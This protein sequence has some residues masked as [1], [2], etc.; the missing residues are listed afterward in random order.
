M[1]TS[2]YEL[3]AVRF[4]RDTTGFSRELRK[5]IDAYFKE[6]GG[7]HTANPFMVFKTIFYFTLLFLPWSLMAFGY[8]G[9]G[10]MFWAAYFLM[11][12]GLAG[13][14]MNVMHDANHK[15]Y[16]KKKWTNTVISRSIEFIGGNAEMWRIQHNVLHHSFTN[17]DGLDEDIDP[18]GILRFSPLK[19]LYKIHRFQYI[20][21]WFFY[22]LMTLVW[23]L[24]KD[25]V[26]LFDY[27]K[28]GLLKR[29]GGKFTPLLILMIL[30]KA[31]FYGYTM[32]LPI[33]YSGAGVGQV[34][35]G[36]LLMHFVAGFLLGII[37]QC[38]HVMEDH[39]YFPAEKGAIID[40]DVLTHAVNT[41]S[42]F[43]MKSK[44]L[45]FI[46]GGLNF[47][48]E[49]HLFPHICHV[50]YPKIAPIVKKTAEEF[51]V[52]YGKDVSYWEALC[53]HGNMLKK[54]GRA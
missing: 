7:S 22:G 41:T 43:G 42:N 3:P 20:Y 49:H 44:L 39:D 4:S 21:A 27:S 16:G 53:L 13:I 26:Q 1:S 14:G 52:K 18:G 37:F 2:E 36:W 54:L 11:G 28:R 29:S 34:I 23:A 38:A 15:S 6:N 32:F 25:F 48:I 35:L 12:L 45:T 31:A 5:R 33:A 46:A 19:P 50:H 40:S 24:H 51:G 17:I 9:T 30:T 10:W 8:L 47:Q